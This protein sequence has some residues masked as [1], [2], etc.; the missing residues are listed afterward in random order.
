MST[1]SQLAAAALDTL[2]GARELPAPEAAAKLRDF[3][4]SISSP[5]P[6][7]SRVAHASRALYCDTSWESIL[8]PPRRR[9]VRSRPWLS[10]AAHFLAA[11]KRAAIRDLG[12]DILPAGQK[13]RSRGALLR[14]SGDLVV[15]LRRSP[16]H[17]RARRR[18]AASRGR[19]GRAATTTGTDPRPCVCFYRI[20]NH[21]S[22]GLCARS[23]ATWPARP[24]VKLAS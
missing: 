14:F 13:A 15:S 16:D 1:E 20:L 9:Q 3:L 23:R 4:N 12:R 22:L 5:I 11:C 19:L 7:S 2:H 6:D 17:R 21:E 18:D 10:S 24:T 8:R